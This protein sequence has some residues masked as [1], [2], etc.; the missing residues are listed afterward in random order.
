MVQAAVAGMK[1]GNEPVVAAYHGWIASGLKTGFVSV[2]ILC[3]CLFHIKSCDSLLVKLSF[4]KLF[5]ILIFLHVSLE[6]F[7]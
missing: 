4:E 6:D 3:M 7:Y 2:D 1:G 5:E